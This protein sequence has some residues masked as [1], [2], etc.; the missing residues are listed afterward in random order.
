[1]ALPGACYRSDRLAV[2]KAFRRGRA[3]A[4]RSSEAYARLWALIF[5]ACDDYEHPE[6]DIAVL[7]MPAHTTAEDVGRARLSDG[8]LLTA[9]DRAGNSL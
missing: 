6:R 5:A 7:W 2:V 8:R 4:T 1:M 9:A 3:H